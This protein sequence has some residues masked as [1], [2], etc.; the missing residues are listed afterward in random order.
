LPH[1]A[2]QRGNR[3]DLFGWDYEAINPLSDAEVEWH[4]RW[5]DRTG[6]PILGLACGT[7]R[8]LC[9]LAEAG[10]TVTGLDLSETMLGMARANVRALPPA[11]R[12]RVDLVRG[13][14][15]RF[16]LGRQFGLVII[17]DNSFRELT[18]RRQLGRCLRAIRRHLRP[19][20][21]LL[22]AERR[23]RASLYP[24][25][26]RELG[27]SEPR[28]HLQTGDRARRR[29]RICLHKH[30]RRVSGLFEYEVSRSD[31]ATELVACPWSAPI[32][33]RKEYVAL[34]R[35]AGFAAEVYADYS[36]RPCREEGDF[37]CFVCV[38][39]LSRRGQ[40]P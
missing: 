37:W 14:M 38:P 13:D 40:E 26:V 21:K 2:T 10:H 4:R 39:A 5:A 34:F 8:L 23:F 11:A 22:I 15:A 28:V 16:A 27:W 6:G 24:G 32:L 29:G 35:Q 17:A 33:D 25:G 3:Y 1:S 18:T 20:G 19:D 9:R 12:G 36:M 30:G 7:A 31:G